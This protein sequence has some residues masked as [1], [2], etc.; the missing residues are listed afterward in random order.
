MNAK[1][2]TLIF[3]LGAVILALALG[4]SAQVQTSTSTTSGTATK[5][6]KVVSGEIVYV[7]GNNLIIK[8]DDGTLRHFNNVPSTA[9]AI[10]N[11]KEIGIKDAKVGMRLEKTV[12]TITTPQVITTTQSVTGKVWHVMPPHSVTLTL[13]DG[14]NQTF[15]IP[16]GQKFNVNGEMKDAW[17][18]KNGMTIT[19][20]KVVEEPLTVVTQKAKLTGQMPPPPPPPPAEQPILVAV[21][22]P[23]PA[24]APAAP[25]EPAPTALPK[26]GSELALFGLLGSLSLAGAAGLRFLRKM[27][28]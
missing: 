13:E 1:I 24:A 6:S 18:L 27:V 3:A 9:R 21:L 11:G 22:V 20:T 10:V 7:D 26:T 14:K 28:G 12:T 15:K 19:A 8:M 25:A 4:L 2:R 16:D 23:I 5:Q 17:S